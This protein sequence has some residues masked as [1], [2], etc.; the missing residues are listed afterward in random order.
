M[1]RKRARPA[2][3]LAI[4]RRRAAEREA[5]RDPA[6]WGVDHGALALASNA[7]VEVLTST[8]GRGLRAR[9]VDVFDRLLAGRASL[10][11]VRRLQRDIGAMHALPSGVARYAERIDASFTDGAAADIRQRAAARVGAVLALT[12]A[13][14]ARLLAA[15]VEAD[16]ALGRPAAWR[17]VVERETGERLA[18]AQGAVLRAAC[19]NL[20]AA[21]SE[22]DRRRGSAT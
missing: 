21:Y 16:V 9:R 17:A 13:A 14:S 19:D 3:P 4:A 6:N 1:A 22:M 12:G 10:E 15:L 8:T 18:D 2:N 5:A 7:E 11:A 20:A